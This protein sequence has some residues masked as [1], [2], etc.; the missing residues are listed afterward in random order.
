MSCPIRTNATPVPKTPSTT[1]ARN[2][3]QANE[4]CGMLTIPNGI[5]QMAA[6]P[7]TR[8]ITGSD[9]YRCVNGATMLTAT[10]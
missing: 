10:P 4:D 8:A 1:T 7:T 9:P 2:D 5:V 3:D 6:S